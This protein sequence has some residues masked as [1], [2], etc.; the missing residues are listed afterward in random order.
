MGLLYFP[1]ND[2]HLDDGTEIPGTVK[3]VDVD[4]N[5]DVQHQGEKD[6]ILVPQ[7]TNSPDDP[8]NWTPFRKIIT[9]IWPCY[10]TFMVAVLAAVPAISYPEMVT[11]L[12]IPLGNLV[13]GTGY[14]FLF[15]GL[16]CLFWQPIALNFGRRPVYIY[17]LLIG[18]IACPLWLN[19]VS[20]SGE[21]YAN[22]IIC[23]FFLSS[24]ESLG[25][26][27]VGDL[28][29]TH[30]RG[31]GINIY[32]MSLLSGTFL[33]PL[34]GSFITGSMT[35]KWLN[36]FLAI[37][38]GMGVILSYI[39]MEETMFFRPAAAED[40]LSRAGVV[41]HAEEQ[42][43]DMSTTSSSNGNEKNVASTVQLNSGAGSIEELA[44]PARKTY[45]QR[46]PILFYRS[47]GQPNLFFQSVIRP[48]QI[49][50]YFLP[51]AWSGLVVSLALAW[52]SVAGGTIA[53]ILAE[54]PYNFGSSAL[55]LVYISPLVSSIICG[56][57]G[58]PLSDRFCLWMARHNNGVRE[59]EFRFYIGIL[60][61]ILT[62]AGLWMYGI[63][64]AHQAPWPVIVIGYG[65]S[66]VG[67]TLGQSLPYTYIMDCYPRIGGDSMV[68]VILVRNIIGGF[69]FAYAITPWIATDGY[70][71]T[72]I[73]LGLLSIFFWLTCIPIIIFGKSL[74]RKTAQRY[75]QYAQ[76]SSH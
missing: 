74:R 52:W 47:P 68:T 14:L 38:C 55:G 36:N 21:Y 72:F 48:L 73:I 6:V 66:T 69:A 2:T 13:S 23:G 11:D 62:P 7:P 35:W 33:G 43:A 32:M 9:L 31:M 15:F 19:H 46:Y 25:E 56:Y 26:V 20:S 64:A 27:V 37:F 58:G 8:L 17:T 18:G 63:G 42:E 22:R 4:H 70:Q 50:V 61:L 45:F 60:A 44:P 76:T 24:V 49:F 75:H 10:Y 16:G 67:S 54:P 59:P 65:F 51:V 5:L 57:I 29:F 3:L 39:F 71:T 34:A 41:H 12:G 28:Y 40:I 30:Q 1:R 53:A